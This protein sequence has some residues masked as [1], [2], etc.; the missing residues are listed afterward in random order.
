MLAIYPAATW[1]DDVAKLRLS[2]AY[3]RR[4]R[5]EA[6]L[7]AN[8]LARVLA[9]GRQQQRTPTATAAAQFFGV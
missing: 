1:A 3:W 5:L 2:G 8:E 4:K 9:G 7:M 6:R